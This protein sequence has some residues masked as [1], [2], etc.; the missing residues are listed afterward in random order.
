MISVGTEATGGRRS[1]RMP[2]RSNGFARREVRLANQLSRCLDEMQAGKS[3]SAV[4][5]GLGVDASRE[6][7]PLLEIA[8]LLGARGRALSK[9]C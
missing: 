4:T 9:V 1:R 7:S 5:R 2:A 6:L 3:V 8:Q